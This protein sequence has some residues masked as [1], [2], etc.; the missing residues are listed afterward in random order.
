M[1]D[2]H[3]NKQHMGAMAMFQQHI[4]MFKQ[5]ELGNRE[6]QKISFCNYPKMR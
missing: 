3:V 5:Q 4:I 1:T 6:L 2:Q